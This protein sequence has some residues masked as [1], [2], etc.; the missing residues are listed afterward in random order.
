MN[1][2][3]FRGI[4]KNLNALEQAFSGNSRFSAF[5]VHCD[6][7]KKFKVDEQRTLKCHCICCFSS[8]RYHKLNAHAV[9]SN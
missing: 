3:S 7:K 4:I 5:H 8:S 6:K 9:L 1:S 2:I